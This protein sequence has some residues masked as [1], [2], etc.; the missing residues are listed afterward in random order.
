MR[1]IILDTNA[2]SSLYKGSTEILDILSN[3]NEVCMSVIVLGE[4]FAGFKG[5]THYKKNI[6]ELN[7]FLETPVVKIIP[8]SEE[9]SEIF[10]EMKHTLKTKGIPLP[11]NDIWIAAQCVEIGAV[12]ISNDNHF[13]FIP[14]VRLMNY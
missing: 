12:L 1:R 4:L 14:Q 9:T 8:I 7:V 6:H 10:G 3:A 5:G 13:T 11:I 2:Y